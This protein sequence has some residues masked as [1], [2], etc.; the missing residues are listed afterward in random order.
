MSLRRFTYLDIGLLTFIYK[1]FI[2]NRKNN[3]LDFYQK[4]NCS[5]FGLLQTFFILFLIRGKVLLKSEIKNINSLFNAP[6]LRFK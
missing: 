5:L 4:N 2:I 6:S 3:S 1:I